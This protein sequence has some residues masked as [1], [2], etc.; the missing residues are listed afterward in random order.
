M[1]I[2]ARRLR[3]ACFSTTPDRNFFNVPPGD[4][5]VGG[6]VVTMASITSP[7]APTLFVRRPNALRDRP[8]HEGGNHPRMSLVGDLRLSRRQSLDRDSRAASTLQLL[9]C[10]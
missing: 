10:W 7:L 3:P 4:G 6:G 1:R 9:W 5:S 2:L 8:S